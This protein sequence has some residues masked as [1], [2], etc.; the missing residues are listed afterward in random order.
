[1]VSKS[2]ADIINI[3]YQ[4]SYIIEKV[5]SHTT[6]Y[7]S[8]VI[9]A[10]SRLKVNICCVYLYVCEFSATYVKCLCC[11]LLTVLSEV[12]LSSPLN[13]GT[14]SSVGS[15]LRTPRSGVRGTPIRHRSDIRSDRRMRQVSGW[16]CG[17]RR[18]DCSG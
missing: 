3:C 2:L 7:I 14:P 1:M 16:S 5:V 17:G 8:F 10:Q 12:D 11:V 4:G 13:Y 15:S 18:R 6:T 9:V